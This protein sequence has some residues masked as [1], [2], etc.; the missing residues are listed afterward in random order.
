MK[1]INFWT[2]TH[3]IHA[4]WPYKEKRD[5]FFYTICQSQAWKI[6]SLW[7]NHTIIWLHQRT[8]FGFYLLWILIFWNQCWMNCSYS[9]YGACMSRHKQKAGVYLPH[10]HYIPGTSWI[11]RVFHI[12]YI[13]QNYLKHR[14]YLNYI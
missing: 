1:K 8:C 6:S 2:A 7:I 5:F 13:I 11:N 10:C 3:D 14:V 9:E 4:V 12:Q